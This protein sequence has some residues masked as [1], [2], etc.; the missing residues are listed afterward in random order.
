MI[1]LRTSDN[2][3]KNFW[4]GYNFK[5]EGYDENDKKF[6]Y[7]QESAGTMGVLYLTV[8]IEKSN[9]YPSLV[10]CPL[11]IYLNNQLLTYLNQEQEV[12]HDEV[13]RTE[14]LPEYQKKPTSSKVLKDGTADDNYVFEVASY[15]QYGNLV[16]TLKEV[17]GMK[18]NYQGRDEILTTSVINTTTGYRKYMYYNKEKLENIL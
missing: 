3:R 16:E 13:V 7:T 18:V 11:K 8:N 1:E 5:V 12:S 14:I 2:V 6:S 17:V 4:D 15:D 10:K 9:I